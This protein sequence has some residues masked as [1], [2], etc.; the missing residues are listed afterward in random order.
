MNARR[1]N[2]GLW[3]L[4]DCLEYTLRINLPSYAINHPVFK[5]LKQHVNDF[6]AWSNVSIRHVFQPGCSLYYSA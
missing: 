5:I 2:S 4:M 1:D 6:V 3:P